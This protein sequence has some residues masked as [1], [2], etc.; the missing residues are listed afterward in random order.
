MFWVLVFKTISI[1]FGFRGSGLKMVNNYFDFQVSDSKIVDI[2]KVIYKNE[3]CF[4]FKFIFVFDIN[5]ESQYC[6]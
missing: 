6:V 1:Y 3:M 2:V 4:E 5:D